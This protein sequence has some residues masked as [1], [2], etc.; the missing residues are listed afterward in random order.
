MK[1]SAIVD[2]QGFRRENNEFIIKE[3]AIICGDQVQVLLILPPFSFHHLTYTEKMQIRWIERNRKIFWNDGFIT[4]DNFLMNTQPFLVDKT[5][6]CK[7]VEKATWIKNIFNHDDVINLEYVKCPSLLSLHKEYRFCND[8][9]N[10][11]Y[12]PSFCALKNVTCLKKWCTF[13]K[14]I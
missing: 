8:I 12:H 2:V 14:I 13:L 4:Y 7:G 10:C 11:M 3:I 6:Y 1:S 9:L 5:I